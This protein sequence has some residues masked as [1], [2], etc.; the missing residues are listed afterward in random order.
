VENLS[1]QLGEFF[2]VK[3]GTGVLVRSVEKGSRAEQAGFRAG[4]VVTKINGTKIN[5]SGDFLRLLRARN[6]TKAAVTVMRDRREQTLTLTLPEPRHSG[7]VIEEES[8]VDSPEVAVEIDNARSQ[9]AAAQ[10]SLR[11]AEIKRIQPELDRARKELEQQSQ[12]LREQM[13]DLQRDF[14]DEQREMQQE[15]QHW[16]HDSEI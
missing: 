12:D 15:L 3:N 10:Q 6:E 2:G 7:E 5:D 8:D 9:A 16:T 13:Q 1:P 4:D 11:T 14:Q